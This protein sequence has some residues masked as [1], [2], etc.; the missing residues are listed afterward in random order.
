MTFSRTIKDKN[1]FV[2]L[3]GET[4]RGSV[5]TN[6]QDTTSFLV[7]QTGDPFD[8]ASSSE[9]SDSRFSNTPEEGYTP[10]KIVNRQ[11]R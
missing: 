1:V 2:S 9:T 8:T 3:R 4:R 7:N 10:L 6:L 11:G 5:L